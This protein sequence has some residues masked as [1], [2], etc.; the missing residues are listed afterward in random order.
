MVLAEIIENQQRSA[1]PKSRSPVINLISPISDSFVSGLSSSMYLYIDD[2]RLFGPAIM[3]IINTIV[4]TESVT[5]WSTPP[6]LGNFVGFQ[7]LF[8]LTDPREFLLVVGSNVGFEL[9]Q[10]IDHGLGAA[11]HFVSQKATGKAR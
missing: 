10:K 6:C 9:S 5:S 1:Q 11:R 4:L 3:S 2:S 7:L 8:G